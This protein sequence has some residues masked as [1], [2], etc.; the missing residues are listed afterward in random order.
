MK[1]IKESN[2]LCDNTF[3]F[4]TF[5]RSNK[6]SFSS[7]S[8]NDGYSKFKTNFI[9]MDAYSRHKKLVNDYLIYYSGGKS[10]NEV[11]KRDT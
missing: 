1:S 11:F 8:S 2:N 3:K 6:A 4:L 5:N 10:L 7:L 9:S